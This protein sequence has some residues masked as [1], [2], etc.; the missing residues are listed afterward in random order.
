MIRI[1][2]L[3]FIICFDSIIGITQGVHKDDIKFADKIIIH[4][5]FG[6]IQYDD[7]FDLPIDIKYWDSQVLLSLNKNLFLG[8]QYNKVWTSD[9]FENKLDFYRA[10][11][12]AK[13]QEYTF[14]GRLFYY[15]DLGLS[16]GNF[17]INLDDEPEKRNLFYVGG[18]FGLDYRL[19]SKLFIS[20]GWRFSR[21]IEKG[22]YGLE[23]Y[24]FIGFTYRQ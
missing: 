21:Q 3:V 8:L 9:F 24:P 18:C 22:D 17:V 11:P 23:N 16:Y 4:S 5:S 6:Y 10:G 19:V 14:K 2:K 15:M 7:A 12:L 13:W 20:A 1:L